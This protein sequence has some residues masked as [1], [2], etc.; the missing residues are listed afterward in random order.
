ML[1]KNVCVPPKLYIEVL[2][3]N[4]MITEVL[5]LLDVL[6]TDGESMD[7]EALKILPC[8]LCEVTKRTQPPIKQEAGWVLTLTELTSIS[9][10]NFHPAELGRINGI[11]DI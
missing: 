2:A 8:L 5:P 7:G 11:Q 10:L 3:P 1:S 4:I 6:L 9:I